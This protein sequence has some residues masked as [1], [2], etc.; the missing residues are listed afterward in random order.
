M[1]KHQI[2]Q[3]TIQYKLN[4]ICILPE[5]KVKPLSIFGDITNICICLVFENNCD[6]TSKLAWKGWIS[7][8]GVFE[9]GH[10]C[11]YLVLSWCPNGFG[12]WRPKRPRVISQ[13]KSLWWIVFKV[14]TQI[15]PPQNLFHLYVVAC[16]ILHDEKVCI[17]IW[18]NMLMQMIV[19]SLM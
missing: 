18:E 10:M 9:L 13:L 2:H 12:F 11:D 7:N 15:L 14:N 17:V 3:P 5:E 19:A 16:I 1:D 6:A 8:Y 4:G